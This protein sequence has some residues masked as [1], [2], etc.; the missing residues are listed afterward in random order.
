[1]NWNQIGRVTV[2]TIVSAALGLGATACS[3]DFTVAYVYATASTTTTT[4]V[5]DGYLVDYQSG[6]LTQ[7]A[8][9]PISSGYKNPVALVAAPSGKYIYVIHRDDS[10]VVEFAVGTDGKLYSQNTY[11]TLGSFPLA[12]AVD[13]TGS[14]L[15]VVSTYQPGFTNAIP[16]PGNITVFPINTADGSLGAGTAVNV[17]NN[18]IG[19]A[20]SPFASG[21]TSHSV[22]V[23]DRETVTAATGG[24]QPQGVVLTFTQQTGNAALTLVAPT[25]PVPGVALAGVSAG[26]QPSGIVV[27]PTGRF[28]YVTDALSN[29]LIGYGASSTGVPVA[30]TNG[31]FATGQFP[32]SVTVDPRGKYL[33]VTNF[34]AASVSAYTIDQA[35]GN[36]AGSVGSSSVGVG[37]NPN[38]VTVEPALGIYLY[39]SNNADQTISGLQL[40]P[41]NGTLKQIQNTPFPAS[42]LPSCL[43]AVANGQH[44]T[45]VVN[46]Q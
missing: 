31:P 11:N 24:T 6:A 25:N 35:T 15:Y 13:S 9:S 1:M 19:I 3:R 34:N 22:Y 38:C 14:Y 12:A 44:A 2:A 41:N 33:Y 18:P 40:S 29:Q 7:L 8:D 27:D 21:S 28:I 4:G 23:V 46:S 39:T 32:S 17:G 37:T 45:Q 10:N 36:P 30:M 42:A 43:V 20:V 16:G 5:V 26:V